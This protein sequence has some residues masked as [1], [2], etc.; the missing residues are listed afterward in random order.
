M[1]GVSKITLIRG[2][3]KK[4]VRQSRNSIR[5]PLLQMSFHQLLL[6]CGLRLQFSTRSST[7]SPSKWQIDFQTIA[8]NILIVMGFNVHQRSINTIITIIAKHGCNNPIDKPLKR[9]AIRRQIEKRPPPITLKIV[10]IFSQK[11]QLS[12]SC[13]TPFDY[14]FSHFDLF[15]TPTNFTTTKT[16][17]FNL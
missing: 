16:I 3:I 5:E 14:D 7:K 1:T 10:P 9:C 12:R 4:N 13:N 6:D 17:L 11:L 8:M 15:I 2:Q